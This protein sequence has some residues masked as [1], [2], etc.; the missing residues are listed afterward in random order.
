VMGSA[1]VRQYGRGCCAPRDVP[2]CRAVV[3]EDPQD[4]RSL[5][6]HTGYCFAVP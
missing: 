3:Y 1:Y 6:R 4:R 2:L 5:Y